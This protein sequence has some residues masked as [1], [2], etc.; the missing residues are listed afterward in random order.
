MFKEALHSDTVMGNQ[1]AGDR[2]PGGSNTMMDVALSQGSRV[3]CKIPSAR[4]IGV[5]VVTQTSVVPKKQPLPGRQ[6]KVCG[7]SSNQFSK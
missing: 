3:A 4:S 6:T 2:G 7:K 1:Y 5:Y